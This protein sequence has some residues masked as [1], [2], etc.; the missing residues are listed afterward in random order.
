MFNF[1]ITIYINKFYE[2]NGKSFA[3]SVKKR[4]NTD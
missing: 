3:Y 1:S 2:Q 4:Y